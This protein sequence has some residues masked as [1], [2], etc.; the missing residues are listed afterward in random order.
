MVTD[1]TK[2]GWLSGNLELL[3]AGEGGAIF[4]GVGHYVAGGTIWARYNFIQEKH[5]WVPFVQAGGGA[6]Y[7]D[8]DRRI[9][10]QNFN[11]NLDL[12]VGVRWLLTRNWSLSLE[13][14][15]QHISNAN[16]GKKN[17]GI[18]ADGPVLGVAYLF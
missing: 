6:T 1:V 17:V 14:R 11:F 10:S 18:N 12:G 4:E 2:A 7:T 5:R 8:L 13:Y 3:A 16:L 9:L 15:Y